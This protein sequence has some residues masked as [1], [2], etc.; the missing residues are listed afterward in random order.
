MSFENTNTNEVNSSVTSTLLF[1]ALPEDL[2]DKNL[3]L[4]LKNQYDIVRERYQTKLQR[5]TKHPVTGKRLSNIPLALVTKVPERSVRLLKNSEYRSKRSINNIPENI[6]EGWFNEAA[7]KFKE[8]SHT[9]PNWVYHEAL[10]QCINNREEEDG[11]SNTEENRYDTRI[12]ISSG[13]NSSEDVLAPIEEKENIVHKQK[14][15]QRQ[16]Q[17]D[18]A[19]SSD[20]EICQT[21]ATNKLKLKKPH[22]N[23]A[24]QNERLLRSAKKTTSQELSEVGK[25]NNLK[26]STKSNLSNGKN[27]KKYRGKK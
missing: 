13:S 4:W 17:N 20:K 14:K 5:P 6:Q 3:L 7:A 27:S 24:S 23:T 15:S 12:R 10:R 9:E 16:Q 2:D 21:D 18:Y 26:Q 11:D 8:F 1:P 25:M 22:D 19:V